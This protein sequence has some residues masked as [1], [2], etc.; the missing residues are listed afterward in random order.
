MDSRNRSK[1][2]GFGAWVGTLEYWDFCTA[3]ISVSV[4]FH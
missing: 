1:G 2:L 4:C 3:F